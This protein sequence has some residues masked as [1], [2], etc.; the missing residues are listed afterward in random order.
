LELNSLADPT[1]EAVEKLEQNHSRLFQCL[2]VDVGKAF[3]WTRNDVKSNMGVFVPDE[4]KKPAKM[5]VLESKL[6]SKRIFEVSRFP[7]G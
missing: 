2:K 3:D 5:K 4:G 6:H 1:G 7:L